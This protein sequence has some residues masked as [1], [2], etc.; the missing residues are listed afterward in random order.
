MGFS[1]GPGQMEAPPKP[2]SLPSGARDVTK[3][4]ER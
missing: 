1:I 2:I 4:R 3:R